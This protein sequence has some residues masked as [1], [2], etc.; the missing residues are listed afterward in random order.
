LETARNKLTI[1]EMK[2]DGNCFYRA[3]PKKMTGDEGYHDNIIHAIVCLIT[4]STFVY[5]P[6]L[7]TLKCIFMTTSH[8]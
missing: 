8:D 2:G 4:D 7:V 5:M 6:G 3:I 1:D